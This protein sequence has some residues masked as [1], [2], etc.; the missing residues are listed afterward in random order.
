MTSTY[1]KDITEA[2]AGIKSEE[3]RE[4]LRERLRTAVGIELER[5]AGV[6]VALGEQALKASLTSIAAEYSMLIE[7]QGLR[8]AA[9]VLFRL[10]GA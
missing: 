5:A 1:E 7:L 3:M 2:L 9:K 6:D 10:I 4:R 8:I